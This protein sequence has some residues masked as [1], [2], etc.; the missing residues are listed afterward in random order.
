MQPFQTYCHNQGIG[1]KQKSAYLRKMHDQ[2]EKEDEM[3]SF[4]DSHQSAAAVNKKLRFETS[5]DPILVIL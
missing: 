2:R 1:L 5:H 3:T 4:L